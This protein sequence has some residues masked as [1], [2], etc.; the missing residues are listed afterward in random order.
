[1]M[2][3]YHQYSKSNNEKKILGVNANTTN[4]LM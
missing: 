4:S 3:S 2:L 1:M